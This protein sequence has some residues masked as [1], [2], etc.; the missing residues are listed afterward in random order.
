MA[1]TTFYGKAQSDRVPFA[2]V[3]ASSTENDLALNPNVQYTIYHTGLQSD[4]TT[5]ATNPVF[6]QSAATVTASYAAANGKGVIIAGQ[7]VVV[8]GISSLYFKTASGSPMLLV[9]TGVHGHLAGQY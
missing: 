6:Y 3:A 4:G 8:S 2:I 1:T 9:H 7:S 5:A